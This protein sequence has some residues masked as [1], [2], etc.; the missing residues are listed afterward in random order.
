MKIEKIKKKG[1]RFKEM[2]R[3]VLNFSLQEIENFSQM[4]EN[5]NN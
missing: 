1:K 5:I 2:N 4:F 3:N